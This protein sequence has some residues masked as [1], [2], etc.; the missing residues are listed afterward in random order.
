M[1]GISAEEDDTCVAVTMETKDFRRDG[2]AGGEWATAAVAAAIQ[3]L[4]LA[5]KTL[6]QESHTASSFNFLL[7]HLILVTQL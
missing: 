3:T 5:Y 2:D 7:F 4:A 6:V 1:S